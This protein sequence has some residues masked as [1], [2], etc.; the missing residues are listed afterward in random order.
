MSP[1]KNVFSYIIWLVFSVY[2]L[3]LITA[4]SFHAVS[5]SGFGIYVTQ[6]Y[7]KVLFFLGVIL[8][9]VIIYVA[10]RWIASVVENRL[11]AVKSIMDVVA[12][13]CPI[14]ILLGTVV[15]TAY[16][17]MNNMPITLNNEIYYRQAVV[18]G[19]ETSFVVHGMSYLYVKVLH[20]LFLFFGNNPF[21]G[22]VLQIV[23]FFMLLILVYITCM[24]MCGIIPA[25]VS[26]ALLGLLQIHTFLNEVFSLTPE[27]LYLCLYFLGLFFISS[28]IKG[29]C[30]ES[31][32]GFWGGFVVYL[33]GIYIG[34]LVY[35]DIFS[36]TLLFFLLGMIGI[37]HVAK[38][39]S[40]L[41][42][43]VAFAGILNG[44]A[45]SL[46][47]LF[48]QENMM[49]LDYLHSVISLYFE[50]AAFVNTMPVPTLSSNF[51]W[52]LLILLFGI[53]PGYVV[54]SCDR[55]T[56]WIISFFALLL[57]QMFCINRLEYNII[58]DVF[59]GIMAGLGFYGY[60]KFDQEHVLADAETIFEEEKKNVEEAVEP[61]QIIQEKEIITK[62]EPGKPLD[63]PLPIPK[64]HV[65]KSVDFPYQISDDK[66][67]FDH[68]I[69]ENDDFDY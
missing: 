19:Q 68:T 26:M 38:K 28:I 16:Y 22:I 48:V 10:V 57:C 58:L 46:L 45:F 25:C 66:L 11:S 3:L 31:I 44:V 62:V 13:A 4:Y 6:T 32:H 2:M 64:K 5:S 55:Y 24:H 34:Y 67:K 43:V 7:Q 23:F 27:L 60:V 42:N 18:N 39:V 59:I 51:I 50:K 17:L 63:N 1:R 33:L 65:K 52:I 61:V 37:R 20:I 54:Q 49:P 69:D 15:L 56:T 41:V 14:L 53:I 35:L 9:F 12:I 29:I 8:A 30:N 36:I 21:A 40:V 47:Y